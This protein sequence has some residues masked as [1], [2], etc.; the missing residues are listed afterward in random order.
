MSLDQR[1][2][3]AARHLAEQ[4]DP[5]E[6]DLEAVRS[7]ADASR[8]RTVA[9]AVAAAV[10]AVGLA[11]SP[12]LAAGRGTAAPQPAVSPR[13]EIIRTLPRNSNCAVDQ[14][15]KPNV[16]GIPLGRNSSLQTPRARLEVQSAGWDA[17]WDEHRISRGNA[18]GAV[19]L[20]VYQPHALAGP[21][22]C[23]EDEGA[24]RRVAP[25]ATMDDVVRLLT[26]LPQFAVLDGPRALPAFGRDAR[27]LKVR[28]DRVTCNAV[29]GAHYQLANIYWGEGLEP[30]GE[31]G[32][33]PGR[34]V[35]IEFWVLELEGKPIVVEA[36]Q[37][38]RPESAMIDQLDQVRQSLSFGIRG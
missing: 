13:S 38:G 31:S 22:P 2:A 14:C 19:V 21:Q 15:L 36:R 10:V 11:A 24:S 8:R 18:E 3:D 26:T 16:Y 29:R 9:L 34:P 32:I 7:H 30:D 25:D 27:Y 4:V 5:P 28:A 37:E 12:L 17:R 20:S 6:V 33:E 35:L 23:G 1:L